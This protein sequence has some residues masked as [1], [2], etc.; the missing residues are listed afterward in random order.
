MNLYIFNIFQ[1][2]ICYQTAALLLEGAALCYITTN[3][4]EERPYKSMALQLMH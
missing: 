1:K 3:L 4:F 2:T